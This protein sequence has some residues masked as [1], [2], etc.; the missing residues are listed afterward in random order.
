MSSDASSKINPKVPL[1][2]QG[3]LAGLFGMYMLFDPLGFFTQYFK[4]FSLEEA[5][6]ADKMLIAGCFQQ[7]GIWLIMIAGFC[8]IAC[9]CGSDRTRMHINVAGAVSNAFN[10]FLLLAGFTTY[11]RL[12]CDWAGL[13]FN[14]VLF[15]FTVGLFALGASV[16][17][18]LAPIKKP[19]Y[20]AS[21]AMAGIGLAYTFGCLFIPDTLMNSYHVVFHDQ[22]VRTI[23]MTLFHYGWSGLF[24]QMSI[25]L[26][27]GMMAKDFMYMYALNRWIAIIEF[28]ILVVCF[29]NV[30]WWNSMEEQW[31]HDFVIGQVWNS[32]MALTFLL[33]TYCPV[34][35]VDTQVAPSVRAAVSGRTLVDGATGS[36]TLLSPRS[37]EKQR[38]G[39]YKAP[40]V[41]GLVP[42][43]KA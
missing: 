15:V 43:G 21:C 29:T 9:R 22:K 5:N 3:L 31:T 14:S 36:P 41:S 37:Q 6:Q 33:L 11:T 20:W 30:T 24:F 17:L 12:G 16:S 19:M 2:W 1:V 26:L 7:W 38:V 32:F 23:M 13:V 27:A 40:V 25:W 28:G 39:T 10:L 35:M 8:S 42:V 18:E 4:T 34:I